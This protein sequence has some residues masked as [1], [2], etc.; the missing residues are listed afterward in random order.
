MCFDGQVM[1]TLAVTGGIGSGK[2]LL[3]AMLRD[4]EVPVYDS[5]SRTKALYMEHP[6]MLE[7]I[8]RALDMKLRDE[9][10]RFEP[11]VLA[12]RI[13]SE[14]DALQKV[15]GIVHPAVIEDFNGW[16][17]VQEA[18]KYGMVAME[19]AIILERP[20]FRDMFD[21]VLVVDAPLELRLKRAMERDGSGREEVLARMSRQK[22]LNDISDGR[23]KPE[24]AYVIEN[25]GSEEELARKLDEFLLNNY[26]EKE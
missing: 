25:T 5:D 16:K 12:Q 26:T 22:L 4:R 13:F 23:L 6:D 11:K 1:K 20:L 3:C 17:R 14:P 24:A 9:E 8:E 2:S 15:E 10:G 18:P 21:R 19:S 7:S